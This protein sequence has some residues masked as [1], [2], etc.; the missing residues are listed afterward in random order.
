MKR[1]FRTLEGKG[2]INLVCN[3]EKDHLQVFQD[4]GEA[5]RHRRVE[6]KPAEDARPVPGTPRKEANALSTT[7]E[8]ERKEFLNSTSNPTVASGNTTSAHET[9]D[10]NLPGITTE[11]ALMPPDAS[12]PPN[13]SKPS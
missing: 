7:R 13:P 8:R 3:N 4:P 1:D 12:Q 5:S 6:Y 9:T 2:N 11:T 10:S